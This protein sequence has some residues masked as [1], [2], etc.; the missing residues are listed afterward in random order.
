MNHSSYEGFVP[1]IWQERID[2]RDFIQRN[3]TPYS[4]DESF[5]CLLYTSRC[6]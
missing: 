3:Y 4:G 2:V 5:L 6:V 1:G